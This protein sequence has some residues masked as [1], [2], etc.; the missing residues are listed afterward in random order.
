MDLTN[1]EELLELKKWLDAML[2]IEKVTVTFTK[3]DGSERVMKCTN[4]PI[5]IQNENYA[6]IENNSEVVCTVYDVEINDWRSF[7]YDSV[8]RIEFSLGDD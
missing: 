3:Q 5:Y 6:V 4:N 1:K 8:K 2:K 7:H